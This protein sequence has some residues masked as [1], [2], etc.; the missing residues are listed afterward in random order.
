MRPIRKDPVEAQYSVTD[1][2]HEK[3]S[4]SDRIWIPFSRARQD[5]QNRAQQS[6]MREEGMLSF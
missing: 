6:A 1:K 5:S 2:Y 3:R 4:T